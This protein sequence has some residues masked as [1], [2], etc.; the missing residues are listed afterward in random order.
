MPG[1]KKKFTHF[2]PFGFEVLAKKESA[3]VLFVC[4]LCFFNLRMYFYL[5]AGASSSWV[6]YELLYNDR[7]HDG[8]FP[9]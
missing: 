4:L 3:V 8:I 5:S 9:P 2:C 6:L 7:S 1:F